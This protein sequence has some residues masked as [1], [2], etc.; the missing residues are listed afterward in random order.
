MASTSHDTSQAPG[1]ASGPWALAL[2][3]A[4]D[5]A[6]DK[7]TEAESKSQPTP[8][9]S[10]RKRRRDEP[11]GHYDV[12]GIARRASNVEIR[13]A[14]RKGALQTHPD[15]GGDPEEFKK[16]VAAFEVLSDL[17]KRGDLYKR[18]RKLRTSFAFAGDYDQLLQQTDSRDGLGASQ[19]RSEE[20]QVGPSRSKVLQGEESQQKLQARVM[21]LDLISTALKEGSNTWASSLE[22]VSS[23]VLQVLAAQLAP[24]NKSRKKVLAEAAE[25]DVEGP[26]RKVEAP[27]GLPEG[28]ECFEQTY[29]SGMLKGKKYYRFASPWGAKGFMSVK[30]AVCADAEHHGRDGLEAARH[31]EAQKAQKAAPSTARAGPAESVRT[32]QR[33]VYAARASN[34]VVRYFVQLSYSSFTIRTGRTLVLAKAIDWHIALTQIVAAASARLRN[35]K[36]SNPMPLT[37]M[38]LKQLLQLEP[39]ISLSFRSSFRSKLGAVYSPTSRVLEMA[40]KMQHRFRTF[41]KRS[42]LSRETLKAFQVS[43][44]Q[45]VSAHERERVGLQRQLLRA[46]HSELRSRGFDLHEIKA[47]NLPLEDSNAAARAPM[48]LE[49]AGHAE[50]PPGHQNVEDAQCLADVKSADVAAA[51]D[52]KAALGLSA[53]GAR[54][55]A[56]LLRTLSTAELRRRLKILQSPPMEL[57]RQAERAQRRLASD[58]LHRLALAAP[59]APLAMPMIPVPPV[60]PTESGELFGLPA[61]SGRGPV[62]CLNLADQNSLR[63]ICRVAKHLVDFEIFHLAADFTYKAELFDARR[64]MC[65]RSGR[66]MGNADAARSRRLLGFL[67]RHAK[68]L[69]RVDVR[70]APIDALESKDLRLAIPCMKHLTEIMLP[71]AGWSS[72]ADRQRLLWAFPRTVTVKW[73]NLRQDYWSP[74]KERLDRL[75]HLSSN[76]LQLSQK[77]DQSDQPDGTLDDTLVATTRSAGEVVQLSQ[78]IVGWRRLTKQKKKVLQGLLREAA[79]AGR[80]EPRKS[81]KWK[82]EIGDPQL[83]LVKE[84]LTS[85]GVSL[86]R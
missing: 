66:V 15:K 65:T 49:V 32:E 77:T 33:S 5:W 83:N 23:E 7:P 26:P 16:L 21:G 37:T 35:E 54:R 76:Q 74:K 39:E 34:G 46:V 63:A 11:V 9:R 81:L 72:H 84:L 51:K 40:V 10:S 75:A 28:W 18:G 56:A 41:V 85:A 14:Y 24:P 73:S 42:S 64:L 38:E 3:S 80:I 17:K 6:K 70:Q 79:M 69:Q 20:E 59:D 60:P 19:S 78:L 8:P 13:V 57:G 45:E 4:L 2:T 30:A 43:A 25:D 86:I 44:L 62:K 61:D 55:L 22:V 58:R 50:K 36:R 53:A 29:K 67:T 12:L 52:L 27:E 48:Q 82:W 31:W 71:T 1:V 47:M 68:L